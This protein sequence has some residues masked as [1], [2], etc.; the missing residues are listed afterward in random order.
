MRES[1]A[2]GVAATE[3]SGTLHLKHTRRQ[4]GAL[5]MP[6][7][8]GVAREGCAPPTLNP[9]AVKPKECPPATSRYRGEPERCLRKSLALAEQFAPYAV[10]IDGIF[11][12]FHQRKDAE[13]GKPFPTMD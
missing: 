8:A 5:R 2:E 12:V 13:S 10:W 6:P 9:R 11:F 4:V 7:S 3:V 1:G